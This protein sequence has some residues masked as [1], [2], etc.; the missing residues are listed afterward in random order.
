MQAPAVVRIF[1]SARRSWNASRWCYSDMFAARAATHN[2]ALARSPDY[3]LQACP[4]VCVMAVPG[5]VT[6][7][8][9]YAYLTPRT[10]LRTAA[11]LNQTTGRR[12]LPMSALSH[13]HNEAASGFRIGAA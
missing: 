7:A 6:G 10:R 9:Q 3:A 8:I 1:T 4:G 5:S 11:G 13:R 12:T 2:L